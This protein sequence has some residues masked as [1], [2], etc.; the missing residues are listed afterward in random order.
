MKKTLILF[1]SM[2]LASACTTVYK[3]SVSD[4]GKMNKSSRAPDWVEGSSAS[5]PS[6]VYITGK[7]SADDM[8]TAKD[9][10]RGEISKVFSAD[11]KAE[12]S[13][14]ESERSVSAG[15]K[16]SNE[17]SVSAG[18]DIR[19][20]SKKT[21]EGIEIAEVWQ[22]KN[23]FRW[24]ALAVLERAKIRRI[25]SEKLEETEEQINLYS[26]QMDAAENN[27][28]RA[29]AA[30][31]VKNLMK[32]HDM[33]VKDLKVIG[34][35]GFASGMENVSA[36]RTKADQAIAALGIYVDVV[37]ANSRV[38]TEIA[39]TLVSLGMKVSESASNIDIRVACEAEMQ[40]MQDPSRGSRWKW[41]TGEASVKLTD[42]RAG[43]SF[44]EFNASSKE[45]FVSEAG[46]KANAEKALG[47]SIGKKINEAI[48]NYFDGM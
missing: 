33:L 5:Y 7:G 36:I 21:L 19:T 23:S 41:Y 13:V 31:K 8:E 2:L 20:V 48:E 26:A 35:S 37:P 17:Y 47:R 25:Y 24:Y 28:D 16:S 39:K 12:T 27:M 4:A 29:M 32:T 46:A 30:L 40:P 3:D 38:S 44:L 10:A 15:G 22:D 45:A 11:I 42:V 1:I 18:E 9:R 43:R 14:Y 34:G 6:A